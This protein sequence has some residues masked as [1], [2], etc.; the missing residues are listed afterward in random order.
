MSFQAYLDNVKAKTGKAPEDFARLA[1]QKGF[2]KHGEIMQWL[3]SEFSL[4]HGHATAIA[5]LVMRQ[6]APKASAEEKTE[7][8]FTGKKQR[9]RQP[10]DGLMAKA[11]G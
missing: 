8:L 5:G 2:A 7:A 6:G 11:R 1:S 3:K 10:C 9:W 4:G